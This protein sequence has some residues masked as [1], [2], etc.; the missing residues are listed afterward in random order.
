MIKSEHINRLLIYD[1]SPTVREDEIY[2]VLRDI[3]K[4]LTRISL[5]DTNTPK[6][7]LSAGV[8]LCEFE[9]YLA[10]RMGMFSIIQRHAEIRPILSPTFKVMW[11]EPLFDY[12]MEFGFCTKA[13][14][15]KNIGISLST[16]NLYSI[17]QK[18]GTI[19]RIRRYANHALVFFVKPSEAR[20]F[21][22]SLNSKLELPTGMI[23][24]LALSRIKLKDQ[25]HSEIT[26][27]SAS[28]QIQTLNLHEIDQNETMRLTQHLLYGSLS[29]S[30][31]EPLLS[32]AKSILK[33]AAFNNS[34]TNKSAEHIAVQYETPQMVIDTSSLPSKRSPS[35]IEREEYKYKKPKPE[36]EPIASNPFM[37]KNYY[38]QRYAPIPKPTFGSTMPNIHT[39][40]PVSSYSNSPTNPYQYRYQSP[41]NI[42]HETKPENFGRPVQTSNIS[43]FK[44]VTAE[45]FARMSQQDQI[46]YV[47]QYCQVF[48]SSDPN[49]LQ[50]LS[51]FGQAPAKHA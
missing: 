9:D 32:K 33:R 17:L 1:I 10:A 51:R 24:K 48:K 27:E 42:G 8:C 23:C 4:G 34:S 28:D 14:H 13:V 41:G 29:G 43:G 31:L 18:Y 7:V 22:E 38:D 40:Q 46:K 6:G 44:Q 19:T 11:A 37:A 26:Q 35:E 15:I 3:C 49:I 30:T 47:Q 16:E 25:E 12:F 5:F 20:N 45:A 50:A 39:S 21:I 36:I 2:S